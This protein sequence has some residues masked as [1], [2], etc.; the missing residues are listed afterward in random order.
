M[1]SNERKVMGIIFANMHDSAIPSL[2]QVRT[3]ASVPFGG[4]YRLIDFPLSSFVNAGI[5]DVGVITKA[6]YQSLMDHVGAGREWDLA[7]KKGGL[8]IIPPYG[9]KNFGIYH[10][11]IEALGAALSYLHSVPAKT[12]VLSDC[13]LIANI[14]LTR[15]LETHKKADADMTILYH[16]AYLSN[17]EAKDS[18]V[19]RFDSENRLKEV[20]CEPDMSGQLSYSMNVMAINRDFLI[21]MVTD[22]ISRGEYHLERDFLQKK[23]A[24][25][26]IFGCPYQGFVRKISS[27]LGYYQA[28]IDLLNRKVRQELFVR[29]RPIY[30]K[31]RD[32]APVRYGLSASAQN[33]FI[34]DGCIIEGEVE[35]SIIF[36]GCRIAKGAS[37][38]NCILMQDTIVGEKCELQYAIT[39][40]KVR[41]SDYRTVI[42]NATFPAY[43]PKNTTV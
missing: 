34:A 20:I 11:K 39:D 24:D 12:V 16:T 13:G 10:G 25:Y 36:R 38:K 23:A 32:E 21:Q 6:N 14:D 37:V 29:E 15:L 33:S 5:V 3:M 1:K 27:M 9:N 18:T 7:R 2:T 30:T 31:V 4:R 28:N 26:R 41:I 43:I 17:E 8:H 35:N 22:C 19:V 42:A 40:K